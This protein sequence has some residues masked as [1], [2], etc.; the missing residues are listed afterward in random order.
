MTSKNCDFSKNGE[1][2]SS[3]VLEEVEGCTAKTAISAVSAICSKI[4]KNRRN[5]GFC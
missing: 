2:L 3:Q 4:N 5:R 1:K